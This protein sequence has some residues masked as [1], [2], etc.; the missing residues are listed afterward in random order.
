MKAKNILMIIIT[1]FLT[2]SIKNNINYYTESKVKKEE[3]ED[4]ISLNI[5]EF[6]SEDMQSMLKDRHKIKWYQTDL[7]EEQVNG[8]YIYDTSD[9]SVIILINEGVKIERLPHTILHEYAHYLLD[10]NPKT[11]LIYKT[12]TDERFTEE[13][14]DA[15][16]YRLSLLIPDF[17]FEG[18]YIKEPL[19]PDYKTHFKLID[20]VIR[21]VI[22]ELNTNE[23]LEFYINKNIS[24]FS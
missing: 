14:T 1:M 16:A 21:E 13:L 12:A 5:D 18:N 2:L 10:F 11:P 17:S 9:N 7:S 3:Y 23:T 8:L 22:K 4:A 15:L 6:I 20:P 19:N 24:K